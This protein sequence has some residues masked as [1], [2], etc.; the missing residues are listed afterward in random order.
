M[1]A[2]CM[3]GLETRLGSN[4][5]TADNLSEMFSDGADSP[6]AATGITR[7]Y[8]F[9]EEE[10]LLSVTADTVLAALKKARIQLEDVGGIIATSNFTH[11]TLVP[12]FAPAL[13]EQLGLMNI[14]AH[15]VGTGCGGLGQAVECAAGIMLNPLSYWPPGKACVVVAADHY[16]L[17]VDPSDYKTRYLFSDNAAAFVLV[18]KVP[19]PGDVVVTH[20]SSRALTVNQPLNALRLGSQR[21]EPDPYFRMRTGPV[22]RFTRNVLSTVKEMMRI[23]RFDG[24]SI[25]PHQANTRLLAALRSQVPEAHLFYA[26]GVPKV[27]N[28]LNASTLF[29]LQDAKQRGLLSGDI[30]LVPFGAE[31]MVGAI[32][33]KCIR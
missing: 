19:E 13:C 4:V 6:T 31:W 33:L 26:D 27:G 10:S 23:D 3:L 7:L 11:P 24:I 8:H 29:G 17:H 22:V 5:L 2:L 18:R 16:S 1:E 15:T 32:R 25:I 30:L 14:R 9:A 12:T 20:A 28:T 21:F